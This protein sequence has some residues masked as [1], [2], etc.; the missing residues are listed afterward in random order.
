MDD[1]SSSIESAP[2]STLHAAQLH[3]EPGQAYL[4]VM[5]AGPLQRVLLDGRTPLIIGRADDADVHLVDPLS[6]RQHAALHVGEKFE[7]EDLGSANGT[8]VGEVTLV[9]GARLELKGGENITVGSTV[10][11]VQKNR[12]LAAGQRLFQHDYFEARLDEACERARSLRESFAL[13]RIAVEGKAKEQEGDWLVRELPANA[14]VGLFGP[15][16]YEVILP[17][18]ETASPAATL[19]RLSRDAALQGLTLRSGS[20]VFPTD[21]L[22]RESL[23]LQ[24]SLALHGRSNAGDFVVRDP[25]MQRLYQLARQVAQGTISVLILGETGAGKEVLAQ[26]IHSASARAHQP[27]LRLN[28]AA[29]NETLIESE[30]FGHEKGAFTGALQAKPGLLE[31]AQGGTVFLDELGELSLATQ[32]KL[33]RVIE[34]REVTRVGGLKPRLIDVRFVAATNKSL[35]EE[36]EQRRFRQDLYFR[37]NGVILTLPPLR[38]RQTEIEAL[39]LRF[40]REVAEQLGKPCP[41]FSSEARA[42]LHAHRWPGNIRELR[43]TVERAVLL[44]DGA[45]IEVRDLPMERMTLAGHG[46]STERPVATQPELT[47][48]A[49]N[50]RERIVQALA[51]CAGNQSRAAK[52]LGISRR[53]LVNR[54]GELGIERPHK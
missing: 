9:P 46:S 18:A 38:E 17:L 20:V 2:N 37:L 42:A 27:F 16:E 11:I 26:T 15:D 54:L 13:V 30:L 40:A 4:I 8:R 7:I 22:T 6:S 5:G 48:G 49:A 31:T 41:E 32:A 24:A 52:L 34:T 50:E 35:E 14:C 51:E 47:P 3:L 28:C 53:T 23:L 36:I 1:R 21:G 45:R 19:A 43:N 39:A 12:T 33:L 25:A 29:F 10:L 44:C